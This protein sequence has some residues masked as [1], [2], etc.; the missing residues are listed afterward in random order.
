MF[1]ALQLPMLTTLE[2]SNTPYTLQREQLETAVSGLLQRLPQL[3]A[4]TVDR[5]QGG[6]KMLQHISSLQHLESCSIHK[7]YNL[8]PK[9]LSGLCSKLTALT[10]AHQRCHAPFDASVLPAAG[11]PHLKH[12]SVQHTPLQPSILARMTSLVVLQLVECRLLP[13]EEVSCCLLWCCI[14]SPLIG[15]TAVCLELSALSE[16][17]LH[18]QC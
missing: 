9:V 12:L 13:T 3:R 14:Q 6:N 18:L 7:C 8:T 11:W 15:T 5:L 10:F 2:L 4:L 16:A 1:A 17:V